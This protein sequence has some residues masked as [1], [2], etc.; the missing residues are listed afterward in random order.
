MQQRSKVMWSSDKND[1]TSEQETILHA[2]NFELARDEFAEFF[3][4]INREAESSGEQAV[5]REELVTG[6]RLFSSNQ[7]LGTAKAW[8]Q[9]MSGNEDLILKTFADCCPSGQ[10]TTRA[11]LFNRLGKGD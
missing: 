3:R 4:V 8:L 10:A 11:A 9:L 2:C 6:W 7:N 5:F 1:E